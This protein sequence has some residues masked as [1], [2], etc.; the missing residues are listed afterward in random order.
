MEIK[1]LQLWLAN[2]QTQKKNENRRREKLKA[3]P[4]RV[5][6]YMVQPTTHPWHKDF[7]IAGQ[8]GERGQKEN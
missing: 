3:L 7:K 4:Q 1:A 2:T 8:I 6:P 5:G